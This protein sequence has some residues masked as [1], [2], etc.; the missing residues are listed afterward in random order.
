MALARGRLFVPVVDLC[1]PGSASSYDQL[2]DLE[3]ARGRGWL[4]ALD[5][6]TGRRLWERRFASAVFGCATAAN[7]VV[8]TTTFD[9]RVHAL[10]AADG[11]PLWSARLR[12]GINACPAVAGDAVVVGAGAAH[13]TF[14]RPVPEIVAFRLG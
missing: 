2:D 4:V 5:A 11:S 10:A 1:S 13:P 9:G 8:F 6:A 14:D 3:P 12:A 7:D